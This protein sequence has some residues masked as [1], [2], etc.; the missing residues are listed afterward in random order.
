MIITTQDK[1]NEIERELRMRQR[2]YPR[3]IEAGKLKP[4][5]ASRQITVLTT[6]A[7]DY[8]ALV[9]AIPADQGSLFPSQK[10]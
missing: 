7:A 2:V 3:M 1:L 10:D 4:E 5:D 6:I 9:A 8:R